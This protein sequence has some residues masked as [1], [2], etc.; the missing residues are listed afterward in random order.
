MPVP[1]LHHIRGTVALVLVIL[2][3]SLS[4][5]DLH[6]PPNL[7]MFRLRVVDQTYHGTQPR[8]DRRSSS[9]KE[10]DSM[11]LCA[12]DNLIIGPECDTLLIEDDFVQD[13]NVYIIGDGV[14]IVD[15]ARLT[16]YGSLYQQD[17][18]QMIVRNGAYLHVPQEYLS[19]YPHVLKDSSRFEATDAI[20][21]GNTIWVARMYDQSEYAAT[22][23]CFPHWNFRKLWGASKL[24]MED[25]DYVGDLTINDSCYVSFVRCDT[26]LPWFGA[27]AGD[28]FDITFPDYTEVDHYLFDSTVDGVDGVKYLVTF[29]DCRQVMWGVESW[30]GSDIT[31][32]NSPLV[33]A[34]FRIAGSDTVYLDG[35]SDHSF[36]LSLSAP[37]D[38]R[39][40]RIDR[41]YLHWW[42]WYT[43]DRAALYMDSC[44]YAEAIARDSS[45]I[46]TKDTISDGLPTSAD[47]LDNAFFCVENGE[48][49]NTVSTRKR[50]TLLLLSSH[51]AAPPDHYCHQR[52]YSAHHNSRIF[53]VNTELDSLPF[54]LDT[55]LV[56]FVTIQCPS[57]GV[58][59]NTVDIWGSS[60]MDIGFLSPV[61]YDRYQLSWAPQGEIGW[62]V[63]EES[64]TQVFNDLLGAWN[65]AEMS[66]GDYDVRLVLWD[67]TGDSLA[68]LD[69][70]TLSIT[71]SATLLD[72]S[73]E[74]SW[75][76]CKGASAFWIYGAENMAWFEPGMSSPSYEYRLDTLSP[77]TTT[78]SSPN[79]LGDPEFNWTYMIIAVDS[80]QQEL[81]RSHRVGEWDFFYLTFSTG[82]PVRTSHR[83][84]SRN[85]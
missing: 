58:V 38:D 32:R 12:R 33:N 7:D 34:A 64:T 70:I 1:C 14:L 8:G 53:C 71:V 31:V 29:D 37:L 62:T 25:I 46:Y 35:L 20:V 52:A 63:I 5:G 73:L 85:G 19:Q 36:H 45:A 15:N 60:W 13:G 26:I 9:R 66:A 43:Y 47:A 83:P 56:K 55:A 80:S 2:L 57:T 54:A 4:F 44:R 68:A 77:A 69:S 51:V 18:G 74:L 81:S 67:S 42:S 78:W 11:D 79:G 48:C 28:V 59:G 72:G 30:T 39:I 49:R 75:S 10:G 22:R 84:S 82:C 40:F 3:G 16:L 50:G 76:P 41:S 24:I 17:R 6:E 27:S 61:A 21:Y 23:T 65:T